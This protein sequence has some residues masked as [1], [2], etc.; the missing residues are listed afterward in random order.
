MFLA[1]TVLA[2]LSGCVSTTSGPP[3]P[4]ADDAE[5]AEQYYQLGARYY[6]AGNYELARDRLEREQVVGDQAQAEPLGLGR[7]AVVERPEFDL[8]RVAFDMLEVGVITGPAITS[9]RATDSSGPS[10]SI[11]AWAL[12][13]RRSR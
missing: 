1:A 8:H 5:A 7:E 11:P 13:T 9:W 6:R 4:E 3:R 12:H 2:L 10:S